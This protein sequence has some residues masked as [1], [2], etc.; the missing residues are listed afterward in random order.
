MLITTLNE[1]SS[2]LILGLHLVILLKKML[3]ALSHFYEMPSLSF[4]H[5]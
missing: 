1:V 5:F 2:F 4:K 3:I